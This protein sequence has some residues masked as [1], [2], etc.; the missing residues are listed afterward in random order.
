MHLYCCIDLVFFFCASRSSFAI[1]HHSIETRK[2][3]NC[4]YLV[5]IFSRL[6]CAVRVSR[7]RP[8]PP[9]SVSGVVCRPIS[10]LLLLYVCHFHPTQMRNERYE[11]VVRLPSQAPQALYERSNSFCFNYLSSR[12]GGGGETH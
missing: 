8:F 10:T 4:F 12:S 6:V 11:L 9:P 1:F 3:I 2:I 5:G 7:W